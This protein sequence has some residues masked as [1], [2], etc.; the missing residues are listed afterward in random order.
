MSGTLSSSLV[1]ILIGMG[2]GGSCCE[3]WLARGG[4]AGQPEP[5]MARSGGYRDDKVQSHPRHKSPPKLALS[6]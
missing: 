2:C 4:R 5:E 3:G 6:D 1:A